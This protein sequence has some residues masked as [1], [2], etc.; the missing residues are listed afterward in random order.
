MGTINSDGI[1]IYDDTESLSPLSSYMNLQ[2]A[3]LSTRLAQDVR[4]KKVANEAARTAYVNEVGIANIS[5]ANPLAV[6]RQ[7]APEGL[8][9]EVTYNGTT[10]RTL[11]DKEYYDAQDTGWINVPLA[12]GFTFNVQPQVRRINNVVHW[13]GD[14]QGAFTTSYATVAAASSLPSWA[15]PPR[16][17]RDGVSPLAGNNAAIAAIGLVDSGN[18]ARIATGSTITT[19]INLKGLS[20]YLVN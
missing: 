4:F 11:A 2:G 9:F 16:N 14:V 10:W 6:H 7:N 5:A 12:S 15:I 19:A 13:R 18:G 3:A 1:F 8:R 20:G 17:Y